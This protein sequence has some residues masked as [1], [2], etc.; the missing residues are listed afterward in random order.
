M[1]R[2]NGPEADGRCA[3]ARLDG[4]GFDLPPHFGHCGSLF[5]IPARTNADPTPLLSGQTQIRHNVQRGHIL[6]LFC[7]E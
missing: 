5:A 4:F 3:P 2:H 6:T 1:T 7:Q